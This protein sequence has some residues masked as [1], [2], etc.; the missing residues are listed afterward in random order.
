MLWLKILISIGRSPWYNDPRLRTGSA[1]KEALE[2]LFGWR[3][4]RVPLPRFDEQTRTWGHWP[5][6]YEWAEISPPVRH[7]IE[8]IIKSIGTSQPGSGDNGQW[9]E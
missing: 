9:Y 3:L 2:R 8:G 1:T 6:V 7:P 5:N 4:K